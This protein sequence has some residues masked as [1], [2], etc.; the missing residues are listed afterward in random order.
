MIYKSI[1]VLKVKSN[2]LYKRD[3]S[4]QFNVS[5]KTTDLTPLRSPAYMLWNVENASL[6]DSNLAF[7]YFPIQAHNT[8]TKNLQSKCHY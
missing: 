5:T 7:F 6:A 2:M 4:P 1:E 3:T 8:L